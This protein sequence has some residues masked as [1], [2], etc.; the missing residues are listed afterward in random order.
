MPRDGSGIYTTPAGT[1]AVPD[2]TIE[3]AKYNA[4]VADVAADLNAARPIVA[5]GTGAT[6]AAAARTALGAEASSVQ[7]T[8]YDSHI[9][10]NGSFHSMPGATAQPVNSGLTGNAVILAGNP[11]YVTIEARDNSTGIN[12]VRHKSGGAWSAWIV[13]GAD[14]YVNTTGDTMSGDLTIDKSAPALT[15]KCVSGSGS[16]VAGYS[17]SSPRWVMA[18]GNTDAETGGNNGSLFHLLRFSDAGSPIGFPLRI[19]RVNGDALFESSVYFCHSNSGGS[20]FT[21]SDGAYNTLFLSGSAGGTY[22]K[23]SITTGDLDFVTHG[24]V[25]QQI[26]PT[27]LTLNRAM[28]INGQLVATGYAIKAGVSAPN[29]HSSA[30][31]INFSPS[32]LWIDATNIGQ[33]AF[34]SDYRIKKDVADLPPMWGTVKALRPI[35]YTQ[36]DFTPPSDIAWRAAQAEKDAA[37]GKE[38][39][40]AGPMF[41]ADDVERWGFIA[42]ELQETTVESAA[43]GMKDAYD[44]IQSPNPWTMLAAL[45]KALQEAMARIEALEAAASVPVR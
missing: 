45:T 23:G 36:A 31:N 19:S 9:F 43:T 14:Q 21:F 34:T 18:L 29:S 26:S 41:A 32:T 7:V 42:H 33:F 8:N 35:K 27:E 39:K 10:E 6:S 38:I 28:T 44:T 11:A 2:T 15:L 37:E 40:P 1:T 22:I 13:D 4:N 5:G 3:S 24:T 25:T 20:F 16:F 30:F 12:Y 17:G